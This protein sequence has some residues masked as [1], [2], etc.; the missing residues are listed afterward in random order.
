MSVKAYL[1]N[2]SELS[3]GEKR[4]LR[5]RLSE[6]SFMVEERYGDSGEWIAFLVFWDRDED[7]TDALNLPSG[8]AVTD[9]TNRDLT[10]P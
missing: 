6:W 10:K 7:F 3:A 2:V 1:V 9:V 5:E 8:C 4:K